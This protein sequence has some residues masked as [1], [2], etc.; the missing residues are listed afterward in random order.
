[1]DLKRAKAKKERKPQPKPALRLA[2]SHRKCMECGGE[3]WQT[4]D[5]DYRKCQPCRDKVAHR[6]DG[7]VYEIRL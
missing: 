3:I 4:A 6:Y 7:P 1:M 2:L 5:C